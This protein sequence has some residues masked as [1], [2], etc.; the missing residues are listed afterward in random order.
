MI[1]P[2][3]M[4]G[5]PTGMMIVVGIIALLFGGSKLPETMRGFG[6]GIKEFK[7]EIRDIDADSSIPAHDKTV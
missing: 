6:T 2:L 4:L 3:A 5:S 1:V 7:R